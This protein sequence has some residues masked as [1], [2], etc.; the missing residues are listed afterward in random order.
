M[1]K[2]KTVV[3]MTGIPRNTLVAWE[4]RYKLFD[5]RRAENGYRLY[6][7]EDVAL[8]QRL[9]ALIENGLAISEAVRLA[10]REGALAHAPQRALWEDLLPPLLCYDRAGADPFMRH[11]D[12]LPLERAI[13]EVLRPLLREIGRRWAHGEVNVAQEHFASGYLR[14]WLFANFRRLDGGP[15]H[16]PRVACGT[17]A[18]ETHDIGVLMVAL[19]F[20]LRGWNVIWLGPDLP[21][22]DLC[23]FLTERAPR[24]ICLSVM[25]AETAHG[26]LEYAR[27]VR[28][29]ARAETR[30][31]VGGEGVHAV[32]HHDT[33]RLWFCATEEELFRRLDSD[34]AQ[35]EAAS[36]VH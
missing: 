22:G 9:K 7:D 31:V 8:L 27:Q 10:T 17:I 5:Q 36:P 28:A 18:G 3:G 23:A 1:Y 21:V 14:E 15:A 30:V 13:D 24:L 35:I 6:S 12:A 19:R 25:R 16:G 29:C 20:A 26:V 33:E 34:G 32:D 4:R 2:V 11:V